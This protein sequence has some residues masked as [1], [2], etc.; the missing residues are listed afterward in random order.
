MPWSA[1]SSIAAKFAFMKKLVTLGLYLIVLFLWQ[2]QVLL[3]Q[4]ANDNVCDALEL[5][6]DGPAV[7]TNNLG[8]TAEPGEDAIRPAAPTEP[9]PADLPLCGPG[10]WCD[11]FMSH[12]V[13]YKFTAPSTT[14]VFINA[15]GSDFDSQIALYEVGECSNFGTFN[16]IYAM[17]DLIGC[18]INDGLSGS[19]TI[20][21]LNPGQE[22]FVA[23]DDWQGM[24]SDAVDTGDVVIVIESRPAIDKQVSI[25]NNPT[26]VRPTCPDGTNG[27]INITLVSGELPYTYQWDTPDGDVTQDVSGLAAGTYS[28][29]VTDF[30]QNTTTESYT[31][32]DPDNPPQLSFDDSK[33]QVVQPTNCGDDAYGGQILA[34]VASGALPYTYE[35]SHDNTIN[36]S[37]L[38]DLPDGE[39]TL[40]VTD[41]CEVNSSSI[42]QT[43]YIGA[44]A[45]PDID[46][47]RTCGAEPIGVDPGRAGG[48]AT[49][50]SYNTD[51]VPGG[52]V[53]CRFN[54]QAP[55]PGSISESTHWRSFNL[56]EFDIPA[57]AVLSG[58]EIFVQLE[59]NTNANPE[60]HDAGLPL[61]F[62]LYIANTTELDDED[63]FLAKVDS[64]TVTLTDTDEDGSYASLIVP[65]VS[66]DIGPNDIIAVAITTLGPED[67]GHFFNL[68]ANP[69]P[70]P[71]YTTYLS[72]CNIDSPT[73]VSDLG[74]FNQETIVNLLFTEGE[75]AYEW[76]GMV[77]DINSPTPIALSDQAMGYVVTITDTGCET[78]SVVDTVNVACWTVSTETPLVENLE[79]FPNP[80]SGQFQISN[81]GP[82]QNQVLRVFNAQGKV[83][84]AEQLALG[85]NESH[86]LNLEHL[87]KGIYLAQFSNE[88]EFRNYK[89][90]IQ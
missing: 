53:H 88:T 35:W 72:G 69:T 77:D 76:A 67:P 12:T 14:S 36:A 86:T 3:A 33:M 8:A 37:F 31:I 89:L 42:V 40:T 55:N 63:L 25:A 30:C 71:G 20:Q 50:F 16:L 9:G 26:I 81:Q 78:F 24:A 49:K 17:D 11:N 46:E 6:V 22:Y 1:M 60:N 15:C 61:A 62:D 64:I 57:G 56:S 85:L 65:F 7:V 47:P 34:T 23:V 68:G 18:G 70:T 59:T 75:L 80:S 79:I 13:W 19:I 10:G 73:Q 2:P 48:K 90:V 58:M 51:Q 4:P 32:E 82:A 28:V 38:S 5:T 21:C 66:G 74:N 83:M 29:T 27:S 44:T 45:G 54:E 87:S 39:Y 43:F 41:G 52:N 84:Y